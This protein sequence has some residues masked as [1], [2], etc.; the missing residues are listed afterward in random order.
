MSNAPTTSGRVLPDDRQ[1]NGGDTC[2]G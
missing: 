1:T 2:I